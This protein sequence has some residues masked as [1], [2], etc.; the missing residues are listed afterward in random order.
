LAVLITAPTPVETPQPMSEA[1][2]KGTS[3]SILMAASWGTVRYS[4]KVPVPAMPKMGSPLRVK[5][6]T[7]AMANWIITH[8]CGC[9]RSMQLLHLPH[10]G[11]QATTT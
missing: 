10:G 6:G 9:L 7:P 2:S 4:A 11:L 5:R 1:I 8:R 3:S